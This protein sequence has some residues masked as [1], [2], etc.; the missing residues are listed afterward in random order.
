[1]G[2]PLGGRNL[3]YRNA[4]MVDGSHWQVRGCL[5]IPFGGYQVSFVSAVGVNAR[6]IILVLAPTSPFASNRRCAP[7][8]ASLL[9]P[10]SPVPPK[11]QVDWAFSR[12]GS[13]NGQQGMRFAVRLRL[14]ALAFASRRCRAVNIMFAIN[15]T[16]RYVEQPWD[17]QR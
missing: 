6:H 13:C 17:A 9:D 3:V 10:K 8:A 4:M 1:M 12:D 11:W 14:G 2:R 5:L 15:H 16:S 7:L